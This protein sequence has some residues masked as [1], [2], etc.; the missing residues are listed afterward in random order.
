MNAALW[1]CSMHSQHQWL[2]HTFTWPIFKGLRKTCDE[3]K[4]T[5]LEPHRVCSFS[6]SGQGWCHFSPSFSFFY[7]LP[8]SFSLSFL[9]PSLPHSFSCVCAHTRNGFKV[10]NLI[11]FLIITYVLINKIFIKKVKYNWS[12]VHFILLVY[13]TKT[14]SVVLNYSKNHK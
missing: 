8:F 9:P 3:M 7:F 2:L 5:K 6:H 13:Q 14:L 11:Y 10:F 4:K 1:S 12:I